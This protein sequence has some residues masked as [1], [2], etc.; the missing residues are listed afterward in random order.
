MEARNVLPHLGQHTEEVLRSV[1]GYDDAR[2]AAMRAQGA[3]GEAA[4]LR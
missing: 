3:F 4:D 1:L 2:L